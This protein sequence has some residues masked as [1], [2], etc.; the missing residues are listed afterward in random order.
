MSERNY[1][2]A[3]FISNKE[4]ISPCHV[5]KELRAGFNGWCLVSYLKCKHCG[6]KA[7]YYSHGNIIIED[8]KE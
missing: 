3:K 4:P 7:K 2:K 8:E 6:A 1:N 5:W